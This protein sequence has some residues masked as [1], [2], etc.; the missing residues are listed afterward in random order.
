MQR[1][2]DRRR[3]Q[4]E[5]VDLEPQ[6][7][8]Q[9]LLGDAEALLLVDD[10]EPEVL[11]DHV[12]REDP[13]RPDQDVDLALGE[14]GEHRLRVGRLPEAR[15]HL[16]AHREVA[17]ALAERV[18]VL[19][20]EHRRRDEHQ[21]LLA[22]Q[23]DRERGADRDLGL[24]EADVAADEPVHRARRL[25]VLLHRLDRAL[26][27][28]GLPVRELGLEPLEP[29]AGEVV[30][31]A[32]RGLA[33]RVERD[34][35]AGELLDGL[36]R[37]AL[38]QLPGLAAELRERGR[39]RV[40][41]DVARD[42]ADLLV[43]DVEP[44][45]AAEGEEEVVARDAGDLLRLEAEQLADAVVLV[46]DVVA[47]A[48]V[49]ERLER[50]A[51][52]GV[53]A[54]GARLR[55]ICVSG[56]RTS[57]SS[58]QTKPRRAGE[59]V[60]KRPASSGSSSPS[61]SHSTSSRRSRFAVRRPSPRCGKATTTRW[62][63]RTKEASS[64][65]ASAS[66]RAAIA[67]RCA[68]K[69]NGW[70]RGNGSSSAAPVE[71]RPARA[72]PPP[73]RAR[74][75]SGSQTRSGGRSNGG[76]RSSGTGGRRRPRPGASARRGRAAARR[77]GRRS[78]RSTGRSAR[79]VNGE[80]ARIASIS[81]PKSSIRS[82][83]RPGR[84]EDV[85]DPAAHGELAALLDALDP[86]VAGEREVLGESRRSRGSSPA[87]RSSR[88][89]RASGRRHALR[90]RGRGRA[91]EPAARRARRARARARRRGA[92]A[93]RGP[94]PSGRR[95][96][97]RARRCSSPRYQ[98]AASAASRASASSG[99]SATSAR[100]ER[101][102]GARRGAAAARA[103]RRA[104]VAPTRSSANA[105]RRSFSASSRASGC[106]VGRSMTKGGTGRFRSVRV[107]SRG[108]WAKPPLP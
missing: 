43:R 1:A 21:R 7:A 41:A 11:R 18:P 55:K 8:Q 60:K 92:A 23:R 35:L 15:D 64:F 14:V 16:D 53:A 48:Q 58:R 36:A 52:P 85:D 76:T 9:L 46:D 56:S 45:L 47:G 83:S 22:V 62:P 37:T 3:G 86:L 95:G 42:L 81:S 101:A 67:G 89:G 72:A 88:S 25:E 80:K 93:A 90:E 29:V 108:G 63:A 105:A 44:V 24:A 68:S 40:G 94:S 33:P 79:C 66:P 78:A 107:Y 6:R 13:V 65:S 38:E 50:A 61:S 2:R 59:T 49:G 26:L 10:H 31:D 39:L 54:R 97:G 75:S 5:H 32:G 57:P 77:P 91:D 71:R 98:A 20:R 84:R 4:R 70:P 34:Q 27:V 102:G 30:G 12:A 96:S 100:L 28:L 17:V 74:T 69:A 99:R 19:L 87:A 106:R 104:P 103:R 82:G 73:R 51:E